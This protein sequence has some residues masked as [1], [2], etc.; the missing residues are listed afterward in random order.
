MECI[1]SRLGAVAVLELRG[2][3]DAETS[4]LLEAKLA[5]LIDAGERR[6]VVDAAGLVYVSSAGLQVLLAAAKRLA[7]GPGAVVL[8]SAGARVRKVFEMTGFTSL[9]P[10]FESRR[11]ALESFG[12]SE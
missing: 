5:A 8:C 3:L 6:L 1:E 4:G 12:G 9:L 11:E 10:I 7:E 2:R